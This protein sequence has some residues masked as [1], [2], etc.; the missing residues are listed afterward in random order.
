MKA[1]RAVALLEAENINTIVTDYREAQKQSAIVDALVHRI[2]KMYGRESVFNA[3]DK[4]REE[5][6]P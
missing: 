3:I 1:N 5:K 2:A 6:N 4:M